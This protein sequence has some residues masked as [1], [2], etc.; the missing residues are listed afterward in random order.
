MFKSLQTRLTFLFLAFVL[1]V[2]VSVGVMMWGLETQRQDALVI[3]LA[4]RQRMLAQQMARLAYEAGA[5]EDAANAAL[6]EVELTFDQ[7]LRL[8]LDGGTLPSLT[9][10]DSALPAPSHPE[11]RSALTKVNASWMEYRALLDALKA[12]PRN[13][14][15]FDP[16]LQTIE[17][18]SSALAAKADETVRLYEADAAAKINRLRGMQFGFLF[19]ALILLGVGAWVTRKSALEPLKELGR[20]A[21]RLGD[22]DLDGAI[23]VEGPEE[24]RKLSESFDSMRKNLLASRSELLDIMSTLEDRVA[25]RTRELD[26]LNEVS[27]E[28]ASQLD[29]KH[30]LNSVTEKARL[31]LNG[32]S[33]L[34]CLLGERKRHL[35]L[36]SASGLPTLDISREYMSTVNRASAVLNSPRALVCNNAQ[37]VG[38]C[39]LLND[40]HAASHAVAPL[41]IGEKVIGALCV[42]S[43]APNHF[44]DESADLLTKL[45]NTAAVALQNAQLYAQAERVATLEE[46]HR[47][48]A[49]MHDGL[50]QTL[51]YL[52]LMTDQTMESLADGRDEIA[53]ERL[54]KTRKTI[55]R[56]TRDVR[57]AIHNLMDESPNAFDLCERLQDAVNDFAAEHRLSV[58]W[59]AE[60]S[61]QCSREMAEQALNVALEALNNVARHAGAHRV[62]VQVGRMNGCHFI[63][64]EDDG[65]GFDVSLPEPNGHFG[66][67]V[68]QAR[69]AH[70][71]GK[72]EIKSAC[73]R[74]TKVTLTWKA[75]E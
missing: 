52:G 71:G 66:L 44:T 64:V 73:G 42:S 3:N 72:V 22:N 8:L 15:T 2:L 54:H 69:A 70:I 23:Q 35:R 38:G 49:E 5:G 48:A 14:P 20:A 56:A 51:S 53:L 1:L 68:M 61:P 37:C 12:T 41:R 46:R 29:A 36:Q 17:E 31:L 32:D 19:G 43:S 59:R 63:A 75:E 62:T 74:G 13:D 45:A 57:R 34:L 6:A 24:M 39:G 58:T 10:P 21:N 33:A 25:Q 28:I 26:A 18:K 55:E 30:V 40:A 27:R 60:S 16:A 47:V 67:K 65:R 7:T 50:G 9:E 11:I 4:G